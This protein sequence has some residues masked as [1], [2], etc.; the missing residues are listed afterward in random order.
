MTKHTHTYGKMQ[1]LRLIEI[2]SLM[3]TL[4]ILGQRLESPPI[5]VGS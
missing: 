3:S 1:E 2:S 4:A 5:G